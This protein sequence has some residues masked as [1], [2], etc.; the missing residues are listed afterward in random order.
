[1]RIVDLE[2]D[3]ESARLQCAELLVQAFREVA[4]DAWPDLASA[5]EE[6][7]D[8]LRPGNVNRILVDQD[9]RVVAW[10]GAHPHYRGNVWE[11]HPLVVRPDCQ[12]RGHGRRMLQEIERLAR[13]AGVHTLWLGSDDE[14][15]RTSLANRDL[16]TNPGE[17]IATMEDRGGHPFRFYQ[18]C[19]FT[20]VGVLP[21]ANGPGKPDIFLAK[22]VGQAPG[23]DDGGEET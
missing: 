4:P 15:E 18:R 9:E 1:M 3:M 21:D 10:V 19:G 16:Y 13:R 20:V 8:D 17:A 2:P 7:E 5:H 14:T 6:L 22:P 11:V 23:G 12:S